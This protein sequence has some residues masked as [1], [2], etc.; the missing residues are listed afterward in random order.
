MFFKVLNFAFD[1]LQYSA[2]VFDLFI[3]GV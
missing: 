2:F 1:F 3:Y